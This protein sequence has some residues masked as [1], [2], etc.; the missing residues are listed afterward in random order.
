MVK[1]SPQRKEELLQAVLDHIARNGLAELSL[2]PL[3]RAIG[4]SPRMLLYFFG[5]KERLIVEAINHSRLHQRDL[6]LANSRQGK[7]H[8]RPDLKRL[9]RWVSAPRNENVVRFF[10]EVYGLALQKPRRFSGFL[11]HVITDWLKILEAELCRE[12]LPRLSA[13]AF[14]TLLIATQ[15]GLMLDLYTTGNRARVNRAY[16]ELVRLWEENTRSS[17]QLGSRRK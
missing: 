17:A 7:V 6:L 1:L 4:T 14:S 11:E 13:E 9:W 10:F 8:G 2:R 12:G 16:D 15:R 5:S 3:A